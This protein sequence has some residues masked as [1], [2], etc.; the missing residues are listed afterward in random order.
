MFNL[1]PLNLPDSFDEDLQL[2]DLSSPFNQP[3]EEN[4][5]RGRT[6][7][8]LEENLPSPFA[9]RY[10]SPSHSST[11]A[12]GCIVIDPSMVKLLSPRFE[13]VD[14]SPRHSELT[15]KNVHNGEA[16]PNPV[17]NLN[18]EPPHQINT[19]VNSPFIL[20]S[21]SFSK[22]ASI[23]SSQSCRETYQQKKVKKSKEKM[24]QR[25]IRNRVSAK[26]Y[27]TKKAQYLDN[28]ERELENYKIE[29]AILKTKVFQLLLELKYNRPLA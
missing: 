1:P 24:M 12:E 9:L 19:F 3:S 29:N 23:T 21:S 13:D 5:F 28:L 22:S 10:L 17:F 14:S 8:I 11:I 26:M 20:P 25:K 7:R 18:I 15:P 27:R 4:K 2:Q 6:F 16:G